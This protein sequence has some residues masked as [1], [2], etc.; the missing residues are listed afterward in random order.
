MATLQSL[1]IRRRSASTEAPPQV[2]QNRAGKI[3]K[4]FGQR[5]IILH[6][7]RARDVFGLHRP[8]GRQMRQRTAKLAWQ[9]TMTAR[10]IGRRRQYIPPHNANKARRLL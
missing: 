5:R 3:V 10:Q 2:R 4:P 1:D 8:I 9:N 7:H 6:H